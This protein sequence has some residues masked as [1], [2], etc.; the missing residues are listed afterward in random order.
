M[1]KRL[2]LAVLWIVARLRLKLERF[3]FRRRSPKNWQE[4]ADL[5]NWLEVRDLDSDSFDY[6][7]NR[8]PYKPDAMQGFLDY[9]FPVDQPQYFYVKSQGFR[10]IEKAVKDGRFYYC[11]SVAYEYCVSNVS[12]MEKTDDAVQYQKSGEHNRIDLFDASVFACI[13]MMA[14]AE[15]TKKARAWWGE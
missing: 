5:E 13:R 11:H 8:L 12:G 3:F 15:K 9:S 7:I 4:L 2:M 14:A 10:H 6:V 1:K